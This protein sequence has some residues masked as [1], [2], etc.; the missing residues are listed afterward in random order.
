MATT[1]LNRLFGPLAQSRIQEL[2]RQ[3]LVAQS[4]GVEPSTA[5]GS[6]PRRVSV[7]RREQTAPA[8]P[9]LGLQATWALVPGLTNLV[10]H[11]RTHGRWADR[12]EGESIRIKDGERVVV[13]ADLPAGGNAGAD[14][15]LP[16]DRLTWTDPIYG[17]AIF[18]IMQVR[19]RKAD[20]IAVA[21]TKFVEKALEVDS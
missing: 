1:G 17:P 14:E 6:Y 16:S 2:R 18:E 4:E 11:V 13:L 7:L 15:L 8:V 21:L 20:H 5:G 19:V 12:E 3:A 9:S 10:A